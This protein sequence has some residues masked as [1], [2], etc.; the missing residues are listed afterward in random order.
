MPVT[1]YGFTL[2]PVGFF[3]RN[4]GLDVPPPAHKHSDACEH[5]KSLVDLI[6]ATEVPLPLSSNFSR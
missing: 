2:K 3:D 6:A 4:P 1:Y 5:W